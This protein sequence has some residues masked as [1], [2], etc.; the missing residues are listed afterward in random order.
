MWS[1]D[2]T[3]L[4]VN[5]A[6]AFQRRSKEQLKSVE[7]LTVEVQEAKDETQTTR[8]LQALRDAVH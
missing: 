3:A 6:V 4:L 1:L 2:T 8:R 5:D 7:R